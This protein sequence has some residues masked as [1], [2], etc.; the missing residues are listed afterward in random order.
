[1]VIQVLIMN[2]CTLRCENNQLIYISNLFIVH[3]DWSIHW[4]RG[5]I[6]HLYTGRDLR[7]LITQ[8]GFADA[9]FVMFTSGSRRSLSRG[10]QT[11]RFLTPSG[12]SNQKYLEGGP[13]FQR[14]SLYFSFNLV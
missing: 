6:N 7:D 8:W 4:K 14:N 12:N 5:G 2:A 11:Q 3:S 1:M 10:C 9:S 13:S